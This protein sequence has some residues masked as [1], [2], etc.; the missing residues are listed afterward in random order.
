M[1]HGFRNAPAGSNRDAILA[2][3]E[4]PIAAANRV[5]MVR[6]FEDAAPNL[7][8]GSATLK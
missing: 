4:G 1:G 2:V 3:L 5:N 7:T 8:N 6:G